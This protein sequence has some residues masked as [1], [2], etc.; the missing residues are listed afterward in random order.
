M[1]PNAKIL[2]FFSLSFL[3]ILACKD[4]RGVSALWNAAGQEVF[5]TPSFGPQGGGNQVVITPNPDSQLRFNA[6]GRKSVSTSKLSYAV[7]QVFFGRNPSPKVVAGDSEDTLIVTV[8]SG[9]SIGVVDVTFKGPEFGDLIVG[10][11][12]YME[13]TLSLVQL[14]STPSI[15]GITPNIIPQNSRTQVTV[16]GSGLS[17]ASRLE[18]DNWPCTSLVA[19]DDSTVSCSLDSTGMPAGTFFPELTFSGGEV[20]Y[21]SVSITVVAPTPSPA[22]TISNI[23]PPNG[24]TN[25]GT[26]IVI[27]GSGFSPGATLTIGG[28]SATITNLTPTLIWATTP[29]NSAGSADIVVTNPDGQSVTAPGGFTYIA[30]PSSAPTLSYYT[31]PNLNTAGGTPV[32]IYGSNLSGS[33][34]YLDGVNVPATVTA[35]Q[36]SF[37]AP[38]R[39]STGGVF[40]TIQNPNGNVYY[41]ANYVSPPD[42]SSVE[43]LPNMMSVKIMGAGF[44]TSTL[45]T[46]NGSLAT[47][48]YDNSTGTLQLVATGAAGW[49]QGMSITIKIVNRYGFSI[50]YV[51]TVTY[52]YTSTSTSMMSG[53]VP[54]SCECADASGNPTGIAF[55]FAPSVSFCYGLDDGFPNGAYCMGAPVIKKPGRAKNCVPVMWYAFP[56]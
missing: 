26:S 47:V 10:R 55:G 31:T 43:L 28:A 56:S 32:T 7:T 23:S 33:S 29:P 13:N 9:D 48:I 14:Q 46:L 34:V 54:C 8:P 53:Y 44:D 16:R 38:P 20:I 49:T 45:V 51:W 50:T 30:P 19:I 4:D 39:S 17:S 24:S 22:P 6:L 1:K 25:G 52:T 15:S 41:F 27:S 5:I 36:I 2:A 18:F 21:G 3:L 35:N 11:F 37:T 12:T 42:I 40:F